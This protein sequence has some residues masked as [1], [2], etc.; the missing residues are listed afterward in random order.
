MDLVDDIRWKNYAWTFMP[1]FNLEDE[2]WSGIWKVPIYKP[3]A[4]VN[5]DISNYH[6]KLYWIP[7]QFTYMRIDYPDEPQVVKCHPA[8]AHLYTIPPVHRKPCWEP[9]ETPIP[10]PPVDDYFNN[11]FLIFIH[12]AT[13]WYGDWKMRVAVTLQFNKDIITDDSD[14]LCFWATSG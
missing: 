6:E 9:P 11:G 3:P 10:P 8:Y 12:H 13:G 4:D 1:L 5:I 2:L 7:F 14:T